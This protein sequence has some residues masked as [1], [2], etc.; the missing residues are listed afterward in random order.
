MQKSNNIINV[1]AVLT[2][3]RPGVNLQD[4]RAF[5]KDLWV[6]QKI[7]APPRSPKKTSANMY[8]FFEAK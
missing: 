2:K 4:K 3:N 8:T 1:D 5:G 7:I 6:C